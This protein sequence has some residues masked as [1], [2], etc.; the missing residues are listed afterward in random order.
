MRRKQY[1]GVIGF[2]NLCNQNFHY[3]IDFLKFSV[4]KMGVFCYR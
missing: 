4:D 2:E 1:I 3:V